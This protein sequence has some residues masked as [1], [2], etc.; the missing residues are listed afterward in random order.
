MSPP[1]YF[2]VLGTTQDVSHIIEPNVKTYKKAL[3]S[4]D[5]ASVDP[6][7]VCSKIE[8]LKK[9]VVEEEAKH[10]HLEKE[11]EKTTLKAIIETYNLLRRM[12]ALKRKNKKLEEKTSVLHAEVF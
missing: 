4:P 3:Y 1:F 5:T 7:E 9:W 8:V 6:K 12:V 2:F 10:V 11:R